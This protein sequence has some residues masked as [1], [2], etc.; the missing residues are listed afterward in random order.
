MGHTG[1]DKI[2]LLY[3]AV[4]GVTDITTKPQ[5]LCETCALSKSVR[6]VHR[7]AASRATKRLGRVHTDFWGPFITPTLSGAKYMLTFTDD[8]MRKAWIYL[9]KS[10]TELYKRFQEW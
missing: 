1:E 4:T 6:S 3:Q 5:G 7:D 9:T 2:K 10:R 8:Y